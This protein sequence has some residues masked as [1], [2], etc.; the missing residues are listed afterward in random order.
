VDH[1]LIRHFIATLAYRLTKVI[2]NVPDN[3]PA[4]SIGAGIRT[5]VEILHHMSD[6]L[7][8]AYRTLVLSEHTEIPLAAW[9]KEVERFYDAL[10]RLDEA[11]ASGTEPRKLS[12]EQMLQGPLS[13]AMTHVGQLAM[14]RRLAGDPIPSENFS[15]AD[16]RIGVI[17]TT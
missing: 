10:G 12:W 5:P 11:I 3:Y 9:E 7:L 6:V 13:D 8:F 16:I 14:L 17:R 1:Q 15:Q 2:Q 4:L